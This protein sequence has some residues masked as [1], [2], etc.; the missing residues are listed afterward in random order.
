MESNAH[1]GRPANVIGLV[2]EWLPICGCRFR[3][4]AH[5][6][7]MP[8]IRGFLFIGILLVTAA[9]LFGLR[10]PAYIA[11]APYN[12]TSSRVS[13]L[14]YTNSPTFTNAAVFR[15]DNGSSRASIIKLEGFLVMPR[16]STD[17]KRITRVSEDLSLKVPAQMSVTFL[18]FSPPVDNTSWLPQF[19][20]YEQ[21]RVPLLRRLWDALLGVNARAERF[22]VTQ[23]SEPIEGIENGRQP[24]GGG[25]W[26]HR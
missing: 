4:V 26:N 10:R 11:L 19:G 5:F 21:P 2:K 1:T 6:G 16:G 18:L 22:V 14:S 8:I 24:D 20:Q 12:S 3:R 15:F 23:M 13:F 9:L 7:G 25:G 17:W